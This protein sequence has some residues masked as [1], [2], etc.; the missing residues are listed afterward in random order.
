MAS[1]QR[2]LFASSKIILVD[3]VDGLSGDS[4]RGGLQEIERT[5]EET[6]FPIILTAS[7]PWDYKFNSL[8]N[9]SS[10]RPLDY[11]V[12]YNSIY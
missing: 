2:S 7:N 5:I 3:E 10:I 12:F 1:K 9:S 8:R 4:D 6:S 11:E